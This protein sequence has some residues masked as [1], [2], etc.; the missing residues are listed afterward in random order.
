MASIT[1]T[2]RVVTATAGPAAGGTPSVGSPILPIAIDITMTAI[3][4]SAVPAT[5]GVMMR[6]SSGSQAASANCTSDATTMRLASVASPAS[7][8]ARTRI[9]RATK[10]G[11]AP[12]IST[13]PAP[14]R[15]TRAA[16]RA[17]VAPAMISAANT[18]HDR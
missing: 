14:S 16:C 12:L 6:R 17:V 9:A 13:C 1:A 11:P 4:I 8:S 7:G 5:T 10:W 18:A 3:S 2:A 15:P